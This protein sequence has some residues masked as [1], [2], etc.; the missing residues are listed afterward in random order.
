MHQALVRK[1]GLGFGYSVLIGLLLLGSAPGPSFAECPDPPPVDITS[2][3]PPSDVCIP[4]NFSSDPIPFFNDFSWRSFIAMLWPAQQGMRGVP[5]MSQKIGPVSG[6]RVFETFKADWEVFQP[7]ADGTSPPP[8]PSPWNSYAGQSP[9][10]HIRVPDLVGFGAGKAFAYPVFGTR[11]IAFTPNIGFGDVVLASFSKFGN[12]GEAGFGDLVGLLP[13]QNGTYTRY[14]TYF[15]KTE[16]D[17]IL[18]QGLYLRSKLPNLGVTFQNGSIDLKAAWIDM[19]NV[20]NPERYYTRTAW[21]LNPFTTPN[22]TCRQIVVGL[23]GL[24][25]VQKTP[26]RPQWIWSTFEQIDNVPGATA[27]KQLDCPLDLPPSA[28]SFT[29]NN[30]DGPPMPLANP[31]PWPP[32]SA[33]PAIFN[34]ERPTPINPSTTNTNA[35]Y[36]SA[37]RCSGGPWQFYQ[38]VMTQ[39]PFPFTDPIL[40]SQKGTPDKTVPPLGEPNSAFANV[41][42]ETFDQTDISKG[43]MNCHDKTRQATDFLWS[44]EMNAWPSTI[45]MFALRPLAQRALSPRNV[46]PELEALRELMESTVKR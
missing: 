32:T 38:L 28:T 33:T 1:G 7:S 3:T 5:D 31:D 13:A 24:H 14:S 12:L 18:G 36:Q 41:T 27:P 29:Y 30:G 16:F 46:P 4:K 19:T 20:K 26:S 42:M 35:K 22:P 17:Q 44:L 8:A 9:C 2:P 15:N 21:V 10:S 25:I 23:V 43:C 39:W 34:V 40:P 45:P 11:D 6:P 37:L